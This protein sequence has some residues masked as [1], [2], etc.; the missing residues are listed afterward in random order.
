MELIGKIGSL[1]RDKGGQVL[2][3]P[4]SATVYDA[5]VM[6]AQKQV[7]ALLIIDD[8]KLLGIISERDYARKIVL[9]GRSSKETAVTEIMSS[10]VVTI[11]PSHSVGD[12]MHIITENRIRHLPVVDGGKVVGVV[13]IGDLVNWVISEQQDTIHH[14]QAYISGKPVY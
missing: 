7:G 11:T 1:I 8:G 4:S 13:S 3:L 12:C 5:V 6:M 10:P 9:M 2:S 14:L